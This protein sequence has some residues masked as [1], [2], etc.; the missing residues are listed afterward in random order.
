LAEDISARSSST[1]GL[2]WSDGANNGGLIIDDYRIS[3]R[4]QG[5][6]Y[7]TIAAGVTT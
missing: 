1:D 3:M 5:G 4:E 6:E 2:T 7:T